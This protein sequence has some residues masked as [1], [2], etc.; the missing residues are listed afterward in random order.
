MLLRRNK[1]RSEVASTV[2][3]QTGEAEGDGVSSG[4][5]EGDKH[6]GGEGEESEPGGEG[7]EMF[8]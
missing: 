4:G 7:T 3:D 5:G 8:G 6:V 1:R 2:S